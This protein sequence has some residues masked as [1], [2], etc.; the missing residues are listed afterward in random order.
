MDKPS[1]LPSAL[2]L[3]ALR[4][5][6]DMQLVR[7]GTPALPPPAIT[8]GWCWPPLV[9]SADNSGSFTHSEWWQCFYAQPVLTLASR[10]QM[11]VLIFLLVKA[12]KKRPRAAPFGAPFSAGARNCTAGVG[13]QVCQVQT[14]LSREAQ[15]SSGSSAQLS[16][17]KPLAQLAWTAPCAAEPQAEPRLACS[18]TPAIA[19]VCSTR[20]RTQQLH[21]D[22]ASPLFLDSAFPPQRCSINNH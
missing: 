14:P 4:L 20:H 1:S 2:L 5:L 17:T 15:H 9:P 6:S 13:V 21:L 7:L 12:G 16:L 3:K 19:E 22:S 11:G 10:H 8:S 18:H